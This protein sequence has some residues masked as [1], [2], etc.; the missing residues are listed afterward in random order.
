MGNYMKHLSGSIFAVIFLMGFYSQASAQETGYM[1][2]ILNNCA[3][4]QSQTFAS[5]DID[6]APIDPAVNEAILDMLAN[7]E[8]GLLKGLSSPK[9]LVKVDKPETVVIA[10]LAEDIPIIYL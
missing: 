4:M 1:S 8:R 10:D 5:V 6:S 7:V 3:E 9:E 2:V